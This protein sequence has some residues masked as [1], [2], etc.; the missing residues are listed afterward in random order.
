LSARFTIELVERFRGV[1]HDHLLCAGRPL[2]TA[3][4]PT[5]LST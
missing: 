4:T 2:D 1:N 5:T 3:E